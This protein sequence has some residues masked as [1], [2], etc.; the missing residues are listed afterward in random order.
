MM[1]K[2]DDD[3]YL[4]LLEYRNTPVTGTSFSPAQTLMSSD[5]EI[6]DT[7]HQAAAQTSNNRSQSTVDATEAE[8]ESLS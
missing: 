7:N 8:T 1:K 4:A 6:Q 3:I 2:A 5:S